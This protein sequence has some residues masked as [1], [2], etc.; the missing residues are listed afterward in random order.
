MTRIVCDHT[1][2]AISTIS[3]V[4][5]LG[6]AMRAPMNGRWV[7]IEFAS[8]IRKLRWTL[9][10]SIACC[11]PYIT[12]NRYGNLQ[13]SIILPCVLLSKALGALLR[14]EPDRQ[15]RFEGMKRLTDPSKPPPMVV[16]L[17]AF[18]GRET[19]DRPTGRGA[20]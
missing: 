2:R 13:R 10:L 8:S 11:E 6:E 15:D 7:T 17:L 19:G 1:S 14:I 12:R 9:V 20:Q 16:Y 5:V 18:I 4:V 3:S